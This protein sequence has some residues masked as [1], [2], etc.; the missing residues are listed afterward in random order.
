MST[1]KKSF[2]DLVVEY[3]D[4]IEQYRNSDPEKYLR[5]LKLIRKEIDKAL[6]NFTKKQIEE[7]EQLIKSEA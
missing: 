1:D 5:C 3:L 6:S 4:E 2:T 7:A